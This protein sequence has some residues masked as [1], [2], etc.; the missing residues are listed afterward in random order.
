MQR[1]ENNPCPGDTKL[2]VIAQYCTS[3]N[4]FMKMC[5]D[6][7]SIGDIVENAI[8]TN[9]EGKLPIDVINPLLNEEDKNQVFSRLLN[10]A[11]MNNI[12]PLHEP[13]DFETL[14]E[15]YHLT[16][17]STLCINLKVACEIIN[18][19]RLHLK[20]K[21][22]TTHPDVN[23][24]SVK[25]ISKLSNKGSVSRSRWLHRYN[26][27]LLKEAVFGDT[28]VNEGVNVILSGE[29]DRRLKEC[30]RYLYDCEVNNC[31]E[32]AYF[33][34]DVGLEKNFHV[35]KYTY[36]HGMGDHSFNA[37]INNKKSHTCHFNKLGESAVIF[38]VWL[39]RIFFKF[40]YETN[41]GDHR[42]FIQNGNVFN[43]ITKF[44]AEFNKIT[45]TKRNFSLTPSARSF[46]TDFKFQDDFFKSLLSPIIIKSS[47]RDKFLF[48]SVIRKNLEICIKKNLISKE[49]IL[50]WEDPESMLR[51][52]FSYD[53][54]YFPL[55]SWLYSADKNLYE[56]KIRQALKR[57]VNLDQVANDGTT[58]LSVCETHE[59]KDIIKILL[60]ARE[61]KAKEV[62]GMGF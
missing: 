10:L 40:E 45:N 15:K 11:L 8:T 62:S 52:Y 20:N 51:K 32:I 33:A 27:I 31:G 46:W 55:I 14:L 49:E 5:E 26:N 28:N 41:L 2:H 47:P 19:T 18:E 59:Y 53:N 30:Y 60:E 61:T 25:E 23:G 24:M 58:T 35:D 39:G 36:R 16:P 38:D 1:I 17:D 12:K 22:S 7:I 34:C 57:N 54:G 37:I 42:C 56:K 3:Y 4:H 50:S 48:G 21:I 13:V 44:N 43:V 29:T 6:E 9:N